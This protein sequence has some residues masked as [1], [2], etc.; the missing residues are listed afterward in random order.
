[1][2]EWAWV[3][4]C[5]IC[6][7][8]QFLILNWYPCR[9]WAGIFW[10]YV[11]SLSETN[12][13]IRPIVGYT[14][15]FILQYNIDGRKLLWMLHVDTYDPSVRF[16]QTFITHFRLF[17]DYCSNSRT[18]TCFKNARLFHW[19]VLDWALSVEEQDRQS[20]SPEIPPFCAVI[21]IPEKV[22]QQREQAWKW[23]C[24]G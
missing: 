17:V 15:A 23:R 6:S 2:I 3:Y 11:E 13:P 4:Y 18:L 20:G 16:A 7:A 22:Q 10:I 5:Y 24:E 1:M 14:G 9:F 8:E 19:T 12:T 21:P